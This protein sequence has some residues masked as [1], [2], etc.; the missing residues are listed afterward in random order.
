MDAD[1]IDNMNKG[2][3]SVTEMYQIQERRNKRREKIDGVTPIT[4]DKD[5]KDYTPQ[6]KKRYKKPPKRDRREKF[7]MYNK[8]FKGK[9]ESS[10]MYQISAEF[11]ALLDEV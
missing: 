3:I 11:E 8:E 2:R 4:C 7:N 1:L 9:K 10:E 5:K 6:W